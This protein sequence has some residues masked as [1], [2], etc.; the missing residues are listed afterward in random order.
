MDALEP[1]RWLVALLAAAALGAVIVV[2]YMLFS[3]WRRRRAA[4]APHPP[5]AKQTALASATR[6]PP[7][8]ILPEL[9]SEAADTP[10]DERLVKAAADTMQTLSGGMQDAVRAA[11]V[12]HHF[13]V[14]LL[15]ALRPDWG[16]TTGDVYARLKRLWFVT[17]A[18]AGSCVQGVVRRALL[19]HLFR[20]T[21]LRVEYRSYSLRAARYYYGKLIK[22]SA[23]VGKRNARFVS[24]TFFRLLPPGD[25]SPADVIEWL[26]HLAVGDPASAHKALQQLGDRWLAT[27]HAVD[28]DA[29][30]DALQ[31]HIEPG[32]Q[33]LPDNLLAL[34]HFYR[35][36]LLLQ[37]KRISEAL[38]HLNRARTLGQADPAL[39]NRIYQAISAA[40]DVL[41]PPDRSLTPDSSVWSSLSRPVADRTHWGLWGDLQLPQPADDDLRRTQEM[42]LVYQDSKNLSGAAL[43]Q[44][45]IGDDHRA[46][47][48]YQQALEWYRSSQA[49][50]REAVRDEGETHSHLLDE[51]ITLKALGDT[52]YL[53][54]Q[55][56]EALRYYDESLQAHKRMPGDELHEADAHKA[57]GDVLHFLGQ[58]HDALPE[59]EVA[60]AA[61]RKG[62][63]V[64]SEGETLL[65]QG[66]LFHALN[67]HSEAQRIYAEAVGVYRRTA[68]SIG[69]ANALLVVGS[70]AQLRGQP[71]KAIEHFN[72]ALEIY[73]KQK[74]E[75]GEAAALKALG[76]A[77]VKVHQF[78][79]A[80]KSY[81]EALTQFTT[82]GLRRNVAETELALGQLRCAEA[83]YPAARE[84]YQRAADRFTAIHDQRG[85]ADARLELGVVHN[86]LRE[87]GEA[88]RRIT[89]ALDLYQ[90]V[91]DGYGEAQA[92]RARGETYLALDDY[93][94][95]LA[96][97]EAAL[98]LW[99]ELHDP[100]GAVKEL[101]GQI[102]HT[103][104][105]LNKVSE[106]ARAFEL[107]AEKQSPQEFGWLGWSDMVTKE[108]ATAKVHF[109]AV[110]SRA[111]SPSWQVG[112]A[113]ARWACGDQLAAKREMDAALRGANPQTL[114]EAC[115]WIEA[116][117]LT[118]GLSVKAEQ[119]D[120]MC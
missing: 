25:E 106:A 88:Q 79:D 8:L 26:Y 2:G 40:L 58:Y 49:T 68:S 39:V 81:D 32:E 111:A 114:G 113:L 82:A 34:I 15:Q 87:S 44:R 18:P 118:T 33:R 65:A 1:Y 97:F 24:E 105:L 60:L 23:A 10:R 80:A 16:A 41:T 102:G 45:L 73:R 119:F 112:L 95:A 74:N 91:R 99:R 29:L 6:L 56:H 19:R 83:N 75:V 63:A 108:F 17:A 14:E 55:A 28:L 85:A 52:L 5:R 61:Y 115:R 22:Q 62:G 54:G 30:L 84:Y 35:G 20:K 21:D 64:M 93:H 7:P 86:L 107:A 9:V 3:Y 46:R 48:D 117:A 11:S 67:Q 66:R 27:N 77:Q 47:G 89:E 57:T 69:V 31:E 100:I 70:S 94:R 51:A 76:D 12:A 43:A 103:L 36:S 104:A 116:V 72:E 53:I 42:L 96:D 92:L 71:A 98:S 38:T 90:Q 101:Y 13:D 109:S 110:Q 4:R 37:A 59:Y 50:L 78:E 120:L